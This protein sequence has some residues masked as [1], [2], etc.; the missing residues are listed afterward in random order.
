MSECEDSKRTVTALTRMI[1][2]YKSIDR[3]C[4]ADLSA[5]NR[6]ADNVDCHHVYLL[7]D[8]Q[9][10][11]CRGK[12]F[13]RMCYQQLCGDIFREQ[14]ECGR[15]AFLVT[16]TP[17]I[18]KS[19]FISFFAAHVL[20]AGKTV[21][22]Q[23]HGRRIV[24]DFNACTRTPNA[25]VVLDEKEWL[26]AMHKQKNGWYLVD[27]DE[28]CSCDNMPTL[29]VTS[30]KTSRFK[31]WQKQRQVLARWMPIWT[32]EELKYV[33]TRVF[34]LTEDE[35]ERRY[36]IVGG[37]PRRC[38][39]RM[40]IEDLEKE[41]RDAVF[42][43]PAG[44]LEKQLSQRDINDPDVPHRIIHMT[45]VCEVDNAAWKF[46]AMQADFATPTI[47]QAVIEQEMR[48]NE[49]SFRAI[50]DQPIFWDFNPGLRGQIF[51]ALTHAILRQSS[52]NG[53]DWFKREL[54]KPDLE[55]SP[56]RFP[57]HEQVKYFHSLSDIPSVESKTYWRPSTDNLPTI[58][59]FS[60]LGAFQ[61]TTSKEH[62][63]NRDGIEA[64]RECWER[65]YGRNN[66]LTLYFVVP[67]SLLKEFKQQ[68]LKRAMSDKKTRRILPAHVKQ[69]AI[70]FGMRAFD[71]TSQ[72]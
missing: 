61:V 17:G 72:Y 54:D 40:S 41:N 19:S 62:P 52:T 56:W 38:F 59:S 8:K 31:D 2:G 10:N 58:D 43:A 70:S 28:P 9:D 22:L 64:A 18:G 30:P 37:C 68:H 7:E 6:T 1:E 66:Q 21:Y 20:A 47:A 42:Q 48:S 32:L 71:Q 57:G 55:P 12:L 67:L 14:S 45:C 29:L 26:K 23:R 36:Q 65:V 3:M 24:L 16:G 51:E 35:L 33:G 4:I 25:F 49:R 60:Y 39:M 13:V 44:V 69:V 15:K 46:T 27:G 5:Y 11:H 34:D 53:C 63:I 50:Y